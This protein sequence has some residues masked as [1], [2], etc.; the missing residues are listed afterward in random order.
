M[1]RPSQ[2]I[3]LFYRPMCN[4][5]TSPTFLLHLTSLISLIF[6]C[7][8]HNY[9]V[10]TYCLRHALH[11]TFVY[12]SSDDWLP[13]VYFHNINVFTV[14]IVYLKHLVLLDTWL[15]SSINLMTILQV[16]YPRINFDLRVVI[17]MD[18]SHSFILLHTMLYAAA[19]PKHSAACTPAFL[20]TCDV[21]DLGENVLMLLHHR[22]AHLL[23]H[24]RLLP[25]RTFILLH[26]IFQIHPIGP[27]Y[28]PHT[29]TVYLVIHS[30]SRIV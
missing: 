23:N 13:S 29:S 9:L 7:H 17:S 22:S 5:N 14:I 18:L 25:C 3:R 10:Q 20:S 12:L 27:N 19:S 21:I 11:K 6:T 1:L 2:N 15:I 24:H 30:P 28:R 26:T 8:V 4:C 16:S